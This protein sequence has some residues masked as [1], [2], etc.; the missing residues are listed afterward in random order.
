MTIVNACGTAGN[1]RDANLW[2]CD[3]HSIFYIFLNKMN[4]ALGG[5]ESESNDN[6]ILLAADDDASNSALYGEKA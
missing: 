1:R 6:V 4:S 2:V 5:S 3:F